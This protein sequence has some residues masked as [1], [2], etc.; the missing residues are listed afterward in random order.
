MNEIV[1]DL[2]GPDGNAFALLGYASRWS[3]MLGRDPEPIIAEMMEANY[4]HLLEVFER[5][6]GDF[7]TFKHKP[8]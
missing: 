2:H 8:V 7:V 6:F 4:Q 1:I 5:E 3:K